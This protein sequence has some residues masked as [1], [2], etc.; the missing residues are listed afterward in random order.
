MDKNIRICILIL[1]FCFIAMLMCSPAFATEYGLPSDNGALNTGAV[2][3]IV[4]L[5][6]LFMLSLVFL[7]IVI[8]KTGKKK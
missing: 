2:A 6:A 8:M 5:L 7:A 4:V 3:L 1:T